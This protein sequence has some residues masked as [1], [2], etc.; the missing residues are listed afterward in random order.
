MLDGHHFLGWLSLVFIVLNS[1]GSTAAY[2]GIRAPMPPRAHT[3]L[4]AEGQN[5]G[6]RLHPFGSFEEASSHGTYVRTLTGNEPLT[7][8][9]LTSETEEAAV[10]ICDRLKLE[11]KQRKMCRRDPGVAETLI[12]AISMS[13]QECEYQFHFER[14]NCTLEG[15]YRASLLKKGCKETAFLYAI[16]S[17]GLTHAMA[18]AC[19]AGRMER[20]TCDEAPDLEN[21]EAWQWGGCGDNLKYSNKF[22]KEFLGKKNSKDLRARVD[23]HNTNVGIKVIKAGVKTTCKCHGVSGS[24]TVRTCWRQLSPFHE[25]GKQL[26]LKYETSLKVG[27]TT[28]EANEATGDGEIAPPKK[29]IAGHSDQIPRTTDLIYMEDS[30]NFCKMSK[31]SPGT[32]G[33]RCYKEKNCESL[34]CGRGHNTQSKVVTRP[35][36]CQVRWCCYVECKQCTQREE[37]YT[38]KD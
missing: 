18:K 12:E 23:L 13:A 30:P 11:R 2:F 37:I 24:C 4:P 8:L 1:I 29:P 31:F 34:C 17:A 21:K 20:C 15:K 16:S 3:G 14:W 26:K 28:N 33:R 6:Q 27:S 7:I 35:C 10:Q 22:V 32:F 38:C 19:S 25:I 5:T 36:Q 9:P